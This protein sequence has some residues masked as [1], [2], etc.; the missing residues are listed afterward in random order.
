VAF[1]QTYTIN[2]AAGFYWGPGDGGPATWATLELPYS[3]AEDTS[4][5]LFIA[6]YGNE[7]I[8]RVDAGTGIITTITTTQIAAFDVKVDGNGNV[9][10]AHDGQILELTPDGAQTAIV[11]AARTSGYNGDGILAASAEITFPDCLA[12]DSAGDLYFNDR[13]NER[14]R[15]V[16]PDGIIHTIAGTGQA[17]YNGDAIPATSAQL[18]NPMSVTVDGAGNVYIVDAGNYRLRQITPDGIIHTIA[19]NGIGSYSG[20]GGLAINAGISDPWGVQIDSAG[21]IYFSDSARI[22]EITPDGIIRTIVGTG[23]EI[24]SGDGGPAVAAGINAR[25]F[26]IDPSGTLYVADYEN[27]LVRMVTPDGIINTIAGSL[28]FSGDG[29]P[30]SAAQFCMPY[31]LALDGAGNMF[32]ADTYDHRVRKIDPTGLVSTYAGTGWETTNVHSGIATEVNIGHPNGLAVDSSGNLYMADNWKCRIDRISP[33]GMLDSIAG[34]NCGYGGDGGPA[35]SALVQ[36]PQG[37]AMDQAGNLYIADNGNNRIRKITPDGIITTYA[38][39]GTAGSGAD[40]IA[41]TKSALNDPMGLAVDA[42]GNLY[43]AD[44]GSSRVRMVDPTGIITTVA[45][46]GKSGTPTA[47]KPATSQPV[48]EPTGVA[49]DSAGSLYITQ[50]GSYR[51]LKVDP[52][53][54]LSTIAGNGQRGYSGDGGPA[55]SG[56]FSQAMS[57]IVDS[58]GNLYFADMANNC[59]RELIP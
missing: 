15:Q 47:G 16:T 34:G 27:G 54:I 45:G 22:R 7:A 39:T 13:L 2:T 8:R 52:S 40:G 56:S 51:V 14:V 4:G 9:Y 42:A 24:F 10:I 19:G 26:V 11:N 20:D 43:I 44:Y 33:D 38:G 48:T 32:V 29:G 25:N 37:L 30:A 46:N 35:T 5:N 21:N 57:P 49:V 1:G 59:I 41:A 17:G 50:W 28:R 6:D 36:G 55:M 31:Y 58:S 12:L 23:N 3:V 18:N 53:G